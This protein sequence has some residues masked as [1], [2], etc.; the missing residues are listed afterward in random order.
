MSE[1]TGQIREKT[2]KAERILVGIGEK[3][4]FTK[5]PETVRQAYEALAALLKGKDYFVITLSEDDGILE[6][7]LAQERIVRPLAAEEAEDNAAEG[8]TGQRPSMWPAYMDWLQGTLHRKL[9]VLELGVCLTHPNLIRFPFE[10]AVFYNQKA[11]LIRVHAALSQ[12]PAELNG[13]G[14]SIAM[15]AAALLAGGGD[16]AE[17]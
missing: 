13:R 9:L 17:G 16:K 10:K 15:D 2:E 5:E 4:G 14:I 12:L 7:G 3:F 1:M 11:E 6:A 8:K